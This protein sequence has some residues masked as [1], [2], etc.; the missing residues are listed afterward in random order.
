MILNLWKKKKKEEET[1][2]TTNPYL[3]AKRAWNLY[4]GRSLQ[5]GY[6][7][8]I[9]GFFG[10]L[11]GL[12][13]LGGMIYISQQPRYIPLVFQQDHQGNILSVKRADRVGEPT[14]GDFRSTVARFIQNVRVV[15]MDTELQRKAL[16]QASSYMAT[17]DP[18]TLKATEYFK[19]DSESNPLIRSQKETVSVDIQS[20][21]EQSPN[22]WQVDWVET[23][24]NL[25]GTLKHA[26][27]SW[28]SL[29]TVYYN[30]H[31]QID[32]ENILHNPHFIFVKDFNWTKRQL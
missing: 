4:V 14:L 22:T 18:A 21:L 26:P 30:P 19:E 11:V 1:Q 24:R 3:N 7:G 6:V 9:F 5:Y 32:E 2:E 23:V 27:E 29:V 31:V 13:G 20:V 10:M 8:I 25:D 17:S 12:A 16:F 28:R 15:T